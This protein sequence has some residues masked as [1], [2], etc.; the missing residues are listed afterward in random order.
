MAERISRLRAPST[1][2]R[3]GD[4]LIAVGARKPLRT[5]ILGHLKP[6]KRELEFQ[7]L[8]DYGSASS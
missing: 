6:Y 4:L 5:F 1:P 2:D 7:T 3:S 8:A